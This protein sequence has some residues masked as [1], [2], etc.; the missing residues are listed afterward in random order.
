MFK[1]LKDRFKKRVTTDECIYFLEPE[2]SV[3]MQFV[4]TTYQQRPVAAVLS[5][6]EEYRLWVE[7]CRNVFSKTAA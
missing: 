5:K 6:Q 1:W 2:P 7:N 3:I 4:P